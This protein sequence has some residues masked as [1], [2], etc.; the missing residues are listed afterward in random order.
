MPGARDSS[1]PALHCIGYSETPYSRG[2]P[3]LAGLLPAPIATQDKADLLA[4]RTFKALSFVGICRLR[5]CYR[6]EATSTLTFASSCC[7]VTDYLSR[8]ICPAALS[9]WVSSND[10]KERRC[11]KP[12]GLGQGPLFVIIAWQ[13][14]F[15]GQYRSLETLVTYVTEVTDLKSEVRFDLRGRLEAVVASEAAK[16]AHTI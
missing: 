8:P 6:E 2:Y 1:K 15:F 7:S 11:V 3:P 14:S 13:Q 9:Q 5:D 10:I 4:L 16:R 12:T